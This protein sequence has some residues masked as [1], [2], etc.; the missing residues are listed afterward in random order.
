MLPFFHAHLNPPCFFSSSHR[1]K[2]WLWLPS[3]IFRRVTW[4]PYVSRKIIAQY[5]SISR[6]PD[7]TGQGRK[8]IWQ[9]YSSRNWASIITTVM[10]TG[11]IK[12]VHAFPLYYAS[13]SGI[14]KQNKKNRFLN[15]KKIK[16]GDK[17]IFNR[18]VFFL[19]YLL[20]S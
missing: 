3:T 19:S 7:T 16:A 12:K 2:K 13:N 8:R 4:V 20:P 18:V 15:D 6:P 10:S 11:N 17:R 1:I 5:R 14:I 9:L